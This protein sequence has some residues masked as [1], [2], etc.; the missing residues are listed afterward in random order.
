MLKK[1]K[2]KTKRK[3][4][5]DNDNDD[6]NDDDE[7][8][9]NMVSI[10]GE[11]KREGGIVETRF[12]PHPR[13]TASKWFLEETEGKQKDKRYSFTNNLT[14]QAEENNRRKKKWRVSKRNKES[15]SIC[16]DT[17]FPTD[18]N[19][20]AKP[21]TSQQNVLLHTVRR[22]TYKIRLLAR[23][24]IKNVGFT[25]PPRFPL[26]PSHILTRKTTYLCRL[27]N[28]SSNG[29]PLVCFI[30][31]DGSKQGSALCFCEPEK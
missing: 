19:P 16:A 3:R 23:T 18:L 8:S 21:S 6:D 28:L 14:G 1:E 26:S 5:D 12:S 7:M 15:P 4:Y 9:E 22:P 25:S 27:P 29:L 20:D 10:V 2:V 13:K 31:F 11:E 17:M 30:F 24:S